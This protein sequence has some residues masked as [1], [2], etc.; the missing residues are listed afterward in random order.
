MLT[1][2]QKSVTRIANAVPSIASPLVGFQTVQNRDPYHRGRLVLE[3]SYCCVMGRGLGGSGSRRST[4]SL[5]SGDKMQL[6]VTCEYGANGGITW[7]EKESEALYIYNGGGRVNVCIGLCR[8]TYISNKSLSC[9][10]STLSTVRGRVK[11]LPADPF[12]SANC[13][14]P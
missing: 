7:L 3:P 2:S 13:R 4:A 11:L 9:K 6:G 10:C 1:S 14:Q 12:S 8:P 5:W